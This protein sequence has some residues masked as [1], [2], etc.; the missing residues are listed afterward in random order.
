MQTANKTA[1]VFITVKQSSGEEAGKQVEGARKLAAPYSQELKILPK[2][3]EAYAAAVL[4]T[5]DS[6]YNVVMTT[7]EKSGDSGVKNVGIVSNKQKQI[8]TQIDTFR[9]ADS[10]VLAF[11]SGYLTM[12]ELPSTR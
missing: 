6:A 11:G 10:N 1:S 4:E 7:N 5:Y 8:G 12:N 2:K 3:N 9:M